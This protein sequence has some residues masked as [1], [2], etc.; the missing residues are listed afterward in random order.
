MW[1]ATDEKLGAEE[2][3]QTAIVLPGCMPKSTM[4]KPFI[5]CGGNDPLRLLPKRV[6]T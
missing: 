2:T 5:P 4:S 1:L 3:P 6:K